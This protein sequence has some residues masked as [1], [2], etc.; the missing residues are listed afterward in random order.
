MSMR[1]VLLVLVLAVSVVGGF[2]F[3]GD[4]DHTV[5]APA[6]IVLSVCVLAADLLG[7]PKSRPARMATAFIAGVLF[8]AGW[9]LGGRELD[10]AIDDCAHRSEEARAALAEHQTR[11]GSFP[12]SPDELVGFEWPG[13]RLLRGSPLQYLRTEHG[14]AIWYQDGQLHFTATHE[15]E[16]SVERRYE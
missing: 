7:S 14:Y 4:T 12:A 1:Q 5:S 8:A 15:H 16:L 2:Y 3:R 6:V 10:A 13:D 9:Y 11:T